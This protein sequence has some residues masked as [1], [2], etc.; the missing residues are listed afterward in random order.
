M[1]YTALPTESY[2][3][4][5]SGDFSAWLAGILPKRQL[6]VYG[7]RLHARFDPNRE[8]GVISILYACRQCVYCSNSH[9]L[10]ISGGGGVC[11]A[12]GNEPLWMQTSQWL[13][14]SSNTHNYRVTCAC[15]GGAVTWYS[16]CAN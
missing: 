12:P 7:L 4:I 3:T 5:R 2:K 10:V 1:V 6:F 14:V 8:R 11:L 9:S 16:Q 13:A 15:V